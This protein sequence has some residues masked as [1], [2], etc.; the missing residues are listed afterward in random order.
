ME[1]DAEFA[2]SHNPKTHS[3]LG[4][5]KAAVPAPASWNKG[6]TVTWIETVLRDLSLVAVLHVKEKPS[7]LAY[8]Q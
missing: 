4:G 7:S 2:L 3:V 6:A 5:Q 8:V 1:T